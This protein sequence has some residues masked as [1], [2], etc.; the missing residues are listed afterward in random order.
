MNAAFQNAAFKRGQ[1]LSEDGVL[2]KWLAETVAL[3]RGGVYQRAAF[4]RGN[5]VH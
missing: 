1:R 2:F 4:I 5:T 3:K